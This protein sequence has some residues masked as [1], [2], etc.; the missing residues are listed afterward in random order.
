MG[1]ILQKEER[2]AEGDG[3][4]D[5]SRGKGGRSK[6]ADDQRGRKRERSPDGDGGNDRSDEKGEGNEPAAKRQKGRSQ[7]RSHS[8][9]A[10]GPREKGL[11]SESME[12]QVV[13]YCTPTHYTLCT[14]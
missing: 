1:E 8:K 11:A 10:K 4:T 9:V 14:E 7:S 13:R 3:Q 2:A 12:A 6:T 5:D